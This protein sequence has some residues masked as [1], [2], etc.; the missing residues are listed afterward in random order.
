M[1]FTVSVKDGLYEVVD[2]SLCGNCGS[3]ATCYCDSLSDR[4]PLCACQQHFYPSG[5]QCIGKYPSCSNKPN[6][7]VATIS[8]LWNLIRSLQV[9]PSTPARW[10]PL[11]CCQPANHLWPW[12]LVSHVTKP[13]PNSWGG[14]HSTGPKGWFLFCFVLHLSVLPRY[15]GAS[16]T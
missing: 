10:S 4:L 11:P 5:D 2:M 15:I 8:S 1:Y 7:L 12:V 6:S 16:T 13:K 14:L 3:G 9:E